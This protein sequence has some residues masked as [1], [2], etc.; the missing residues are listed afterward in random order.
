MQGQA[1]RHR[2][3]RAASIKRRVPSWVENLSEQYKGG[4]CIFFLNTYATQ[5][6]DGP[7]IWKAGPDGLVCSGRPRRIVVGEQHPSN[8]APPVGS[9]NVSAQYNGGSC[10]FIIIICFNERPRLAV[11]HL[12]GRRAAGPDGPFRRPRRRGGRATSRRN[13]QRTNS[14]VIMSATHIFPLAPSLHYNMWK[15]A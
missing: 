5:A 11:G 10:I 7:A 2:G 3:R 15:I 13:H 9:K 6:S 8:A 12:A 1:S 14:R 4:S